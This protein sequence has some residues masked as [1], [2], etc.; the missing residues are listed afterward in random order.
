MVFI[1][2]GLVLLLLAAAIFWA[3][4]R[5]TGKQVASLTWPTC[6]GRIVSAYVQSSRGDEEGEVQY[7]PR[8]K[9]AYEVDGR[10]YSSERIVWGGR[11][12][13]TLPNHAETVVDRYPA[14]SVV[15]VHYN[16]H[17]PREA[18]LDPTETAGLSLL[19]FLSAGIAALGVLFLAFGVFV[20]G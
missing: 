19:G 20:P 11:A 2:I 10:R 13:G 5:S 1:L 6:E 12:S 4:R 7:R 16:P 14:G 8:I 17:R 9:Y 3:R 15:P 18:V